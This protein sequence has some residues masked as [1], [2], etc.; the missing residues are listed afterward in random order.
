MIRYLL[1]FFISLVAVQAT[2]QQQYLLSGRITDNENKPV[3]FASVYISNTTYGT[4]ANQEG[5][6]Q[7]KLS[8]GTY[9]VVYRNVGYIERKVRVTITNRD[10]VQNQQLQLETFQL[11]AVEISGDTT[12]P[13]A[14]IIRKVI[15]NRERYLSQVKQYS[16]VVYVKGVQQLVSVPKAVIKN[17]FARRFARRL[18]IDTTNGK[19]IIY[20]SESISTFSFEQ[21]RHIKEVMISSKTAGQ[22]NSFSYN[23]AADLQINFYENTAVI[24]GVSP[25]AFISPVADNALD[26]YSYRLVGTSVEDGRVIYKILAMPTHEHDQA[27]RGFVYV[28]KD[29]WRIYGID[30]YITKQANINFVDTLNITQQFVP[31]RDTVWM[32]ITTQFDFKGDALGVK[33]KGYYLGVYNNYNINPQFSPKYFDG[34]VLRIDTNANQKPNGYWARNRPVPLTAL[35]AVDYRKKDS[36]A[37]I[38]NQPEY[39]DSLENRQNKFRV[40]RYITLGYQHYNRD[41]R[42]SVYVYPI[43]EQIFYNTVQGWGVNPKITYLKG[44]DNRQSIS[45]TPALRYGFTEKKLDANLTVSYNYDP[46]HQGYW[47]LRGGSDVLDLSNVGTRSIPFNSISTLLYGNNYVK[48]YRSQFGLVG[49]QREVSNG[50]VVY[51]GLSYANRQQL[52]NQSFNRIFYQ[53]RAYRANSSLGPDGIYRNTEVPPEAYVERKIFDENQALTFKA[54]VNITFDQQYQTR[55]EGKIYEPSKLPTL[56]VTYRKGINNLLGSDVNYDLVSA[57]I[58]QNRLGFGL[59]GYSSYKLTI[60]SFLNHQSLYFMDYNHFLGNQGTVF[61]PDIGNFH[62]LP[63]YAN[64]ANR[65]FLEA[66]YE[67]NF[68]GRLLGEVPYIRRLKI[69]TIAG[70]N[71]L[72]ANNA[73]ITADPYFQGNA[74][75]NYVEGYVGIKRF[76]FRID[77]GVAFRAGQKFAQGIRIF[78]GIK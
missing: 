45:I 69:E 59:W 25:K 49:W 9:T 38:R 42:T 17:K 57:S 48:Y 71:Y 16:C 60:G 37:E 39:I 50:V 3:S 29:D 8:P 68:T 75:R 67:H 65:N 54:S 14:R 21:P 22:N 20:Q 47:F 73:P 26:H 30:M 18:Q 44:F 2:A 46:D 35:E 28:I 40:L 24:S 76:F 72:Y 77:Y 66:H 12:N 11:Q 78:Y 13:G 1:F 23:R 36:V 6:Y 41:T 62:Y 7:F 61:N 58:Y 63:F 19:G 31:V 4:S 64:S 5:R 34:E 27:Y 55:P 74:V 52:V 10:V 53:D 51:A 56:Q 70:L 33:F 43:Y 32:P 15:D